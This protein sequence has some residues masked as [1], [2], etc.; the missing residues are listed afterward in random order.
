MTNSIYKSGLKRILSLVLAICMLFTAA[1]LSFATDGDD[2]FGTYGNTSVEPAEDLY[3]SIQKAY[4][5]DTAL[6]ILEGITYA[7]MTVGDA[8]EINAY[9]GTNCSWYDTD[10]W[11]FLSQTPAKAD[12]GNSAY[13]KFFGGSYGL[14]MW[15]KGT[16][17][18]IKVKANAG[19]YLPA[20][21]PYNIVGAGGLI[22]ASFYTYDAQSGSKGEL[23]AES[24]EIDTN[25]EYLTGEV[26]VPLSDTPLLLTEGEYVFRIEVTGTG[27]LPGARAWA[28]IN[29][30]A[31]NAVH[32]RPEIPKSIPVGESAEIPVYTA[33]HGVKLAS[34]S[35]EA[36]AADDTV[37]STATDTTTSTVT[38]QGLKAGTTTVTI[39][40]QGALN[41][42][43]TIPVTIYDPNTD[44]SK[45]FRYD[46]VKANTRAQSDVEVTWID[47]YNYAMPGTSEEY[48]TE[49][50][51]TDQYTLAPWKYFT[52][53]GSIEGLNQYRRYRNASYGIYMAGVVRTQYKILVPES[54]DYQINTYMAYY[55]GTSQALELSLAP[56]EADGTV[57][58]F[59]TLGSL[60][61]NTT[62]GTAFGKKATFDGTHQL[63][64]GEY[65]L[66]FNNKTKAIAY[67]ADA[68]ELESVKKAATL[69]VSAQETASVEKG[70][71]ASVP[72]TIT[73]SDS[74]AVDYTQATV[75]CTYGTADIVN[76]IVNKSADGITLQVEGLQAGSTTVTANV[77]ADGLTASASFTVTVTAPA[78][79]ED[80]GYYYDMFKVWDDAKTGTDESSHFYITTITY[81][82]TKQGG[83]SELNTS[84]YSDPWAYVSHNPTGAYNAANGLGGNRYIKFFAGQKTWGLAFANAGSASANNVKLS[85]KVEVD[86]DGLYQPFVKLCHGDACST[87]KATLETTDGTVLA[88]LN[89]YDSNG[90]ND[91]VKDV[92]IGD[93][94]ELKAGEYIF[95]LQATGT[96]KRAYLNGFGLKSAS[97]SEDPATLTVSAQD[98]ATVEA[99]SSVSVPL[100]ITRSDNQTVDYTQAEV[101]CEYGTAGVATV[102]PAKTAEGVTLQ[103]NGD[104]EGST[105]VTVN[106]AA[107][108]LT[109]SA[110][111]QVTVTPKGGAEAK[112]LYFN[113]YKIYTADARGNGSYID[114]IDYSK[115]TIGSG[116]SEINKYTQG[117][118]IKY[119]SDPWA[120]VSKHVAD[121]GYIQF[122]GFDYGLA[123]YKVGSK[124][125]VKVRVPADGVYQPMVDLTHLGGGCGNMQVTFSEYDS[126]SNAAGKTLAQSEVIN[127]GLTKQNGGVISPVGGQA[128]SLKAGEYAFTAELMAG[129]AALGIV[130]AFRLNVVRVRPEIPAPLKIGDTTTLSAFTGGSDVSV[131]SDKLE[132]TAS[133]DSIAGVTADATTG[134]LTLTAKAAGTVEVTV[135]AEGTV[136][137]SY[138]FPVTV[139]DPDAINTNT[140]RYDF[141]KANTYTN[142]NVDAQDV[143]LYNQTVSGV[144]D[145][146]NPAAADANVV[147]SPWKFY[148]WQGSLRDTTRA[149]YVSTEHGISMSSGGSGVVNFAYRIRVPMD[150]MYQMSQFAKVGAKETKGLTIKLSKLDANGVPQDISTL[151]TLNLGADEDQYGVENKLSG[152]VTLQAGEYL[153]IYSMGAGNTATVDSFNL[154]PVALD[155]DVT[156]PSAPVIID[157]TMNVP[158]DVTMLDGSPVD[159][160]NMSVQVS[161]SEDGIVEATPVIDTQEG[162][163]KIQVTGLSLGS[164]Q[165]TAKITVNGVSRVVNFLV[166]VDDGRAKDL[167]YDFQKG[168]TKL[169]STDYLQGITYNSTTAGAEGELNPGKYPTTPWAFHSWSLSAGGYFK[170]NYENTGIYMYR[171]GIAY[172]K[173]KV[174]ADGLYLP[175]ALIGCTTASGTPYGNVQ[176]FLMDYDAVTGKIGDELSK[177]EVIDYCSKTEAKMWIPMGNQP[178][179]L[180]AGEYIFGYEMSSSGSNYR[181]ALDAFRLNAIRLEPEAPRSI[182]VGE[183]V[184]I[185]AFRG[186]QLACDS[187][188]ASAAPS[189]IVDVSIDKQTGKLTLTGVAEGKTKLTVTAQGDYAGSYTIPV[190]VIDTENP[191]PDSVYYDF[192]KANT[193][194]DT[195]IRAL[196][197][198]SYNKT[199]GGA[200]DEINPSATND[201]DAQ[202]G[203][204]KYF[205]WYGDTTGDAFFGF[206]NASYGL[207]LNHR[208]TGMLRVVVPE[209]G[210]YQVAPVLSKL[211]NGGTVTI[212]I[213]PITG[214]GIPGKKTEFG[215]VVTKSDTVAH[216]VYTVLPGVLEI[217]AGEYILTVEMTDTAF[218]PKAIIDGILLKKLDV[219]TYVPGVAVARDGSKKQAVTATDSTG[220]AVDMT[221][222]VVTIRNSNDSIADVSSVIEDAKLYFQIDGKKNGS[223]TINF[224]FTLPDGRVGA[225]EFGIFVNPAGVVVADDLRYNFHKLD[226]WKETGNTDDKHK[227]VDIATVTSFAQTTAGDPQEIN[228]NSSELTDPWY[229]ESVAATQLRYA[230]SDYGLIFDYEPATAVFKIRVPADGLYQAVSENMQFTS[231]A[232]LKLYLAPDGAADPMADEYYLGSVDTYAQ[233]QDNA[234][235]NG[236]KIRNLTAGDYTLTYRM[237]GKNEA[238]RSAG[239][240]GIGAF[241]LNGMDSE[242]IVNATVDGPDMI[243]I[244]EIAEYTIN[245]QESDGLNGWTA[246][247]DIEVTQS[248]DGVLDTEVIYNSDK[249]A[250]KVKVTAVGN[251]NTIMSVKV[252]VNGVEKIISIPLTV[253]DPAA[254][255]DRDYKYTFI[256]SLPLSSKIAIVD[257]FSKTMAGSPDELRP[258]SGTDPWCF[259]FQQASDFYIPSDVYG[260]CLGIRPGAAAGIKIRLPVSGMFRPEMPYVAGNQCGEVRMYIAPADA[261][262]PMA[263]EYSVGKVDTYNENT[264]PL[265]NALF[266]SRWMDAGDYIVSWKL[267]GEDRSIEKKS[268]IWFGGVNL[269]A[270]NEFPEIDVTVGELAAVKLGNT[271]TTKIS[272]TVADGAPED[273]YGAEFRVESDVENAVTVEPKINDD[274]TADLAVTGL[275]VCKTDVDVILVLNGSDRARFTLPVEILAPGKLKT[276]QPK[277]TDNDEG[278]IVLRGTYENEKQ[279]TC[280]L[281][282]EE[283]VEISEFSA[284]LQGATYRYESENPSIA[285]VTE[286]GK[287]TPVSAGVTTVRATV[288]IAG[289]T[290]TGEMQ[291]TVSAGKTRS[292]YYTAEKVANARE[293][294]N[295]YDW[296]RSTKNAAASAG[297]KYVGMEDKLWSLV[298]TQ[299][300]PRSYYVGYR[301]DPEAGYCRYP[302][303]KVNIAAEYGSL[304]AWITDPLT[305]PWQVQCPKCRRKFPSNDFGSFYELGIDEHG[306]WSY[307]L[308]KQKNAELVAAGEDGYLVNKAY[309]EV[310]KQ[311]HVTGWGVDDGYGYDSGNMYSNGVKEV[312]T[313]ISFYNHWAI[314]HANG[315]LYTTVDALK[316]AYLYTG[317]AKYGRAGAILVDRIADVYPTLDTRPYRWQLTADASY[318]PKGKAVD[319]IWENQLARDY[320]KA[321]DAF[322]PMYD[323][324]TVIRFLSEKAEKYDLENP[325]TSANLIREN[326]ED[327]ILR[328]TFRAAQC[329]LLN[330]NFGMTQSAVAAAA[331]VLDTM[332]ETR[333]MLDWVFQDGET[334]VLDASSA[335]SQPDLITGGNVQRQIID[336]VDRD[337]VSDE[338]APNYANIW[339]GGLNTMM[340]VLEGYD[341]YPEMDMY[342]NPRVI[343]MLAGMHPLT[344]SRRSTVQIGDS[345]A[346]A[347]QDK[348]I[349]ASRALPAFKNT[350]IA[351]FGQILYF[352]NGNKSNGLHY[353]IFTKD[354][355]SLAKDVQKVIDA[356]GEYPFDDSKMLPG[357]GLAALRG[358]TQFKTQN[359]VVDSQRTFWMNFN[360]GAGHGHND[361]LN[362]GVEAYGLNIAPE[363]GYP[364]KVVG[365]VYPNWGKATVS[366]NTVVVNNTTQSRPSVTSNPLHFDDAGMVQVM[367]VDASERYG[368]TSNY[369]R[370]VVTVDA[371]D[372]ISYGVDFFRVTGGNDHTYSFHALTNLTPQ[373]GELDGTAI[374]MTPQKDANGNY[375]G[376]YAGANVP[377]EQA[378]VTSG[379]SYLKNV[380]RAAQPGNELYVDFKIQDF[381]KTI[382]TDYELYLRLT[383]LNDFD[384]SELAIAE[385]KPAEA[386]DNPEGLKFMLAKRTGANLDSLFTT[387][388]EPYNKERYVESMA[389]VPVTRADGSA[390]A[391]PAEVKAVKVTLTN[392]RSD[393][394]VYAA[395]KSI[396]YRVDDLF[397]FQGFVGVYSVKDGENVYAYL[398]DGTKLGDMRGET[399]YTGSVTGFTKE[400]SLENTITIAADQ[401]VDPAELEGKFI[402]ID[403]GASGNG[404][405]EI[406][407]A[408]SADGKNISLEIGDVTLIH[409][410]NTATAGEYTYYYNIAEGARFQIPRTALVD[411]RPVFE[412]VGNGRVFAENRYSVTVSAV[413]PID[414]ELSYEAVSLPRGA[415]FD[416]ATHTLTWTPDSSQIGVHHVAISAS[417]GALTATVHFEVQVAQ[418]GTGG[419][420]GGA[421]PNPEPDPEPNPDPDPTPNPDPDPDPTPGERFID[422][423]GYDWAKDAINELAEAGVIKGTSANT[424]SPGANITRADFAL[425]LTRAFKLTS[426]STENFADVAANKY[427]AAELAIAKANGIVNGIGNNKFKPEG[428][429]TRQDMMVMLERALKK[430]GYELGEAEGSELAAFSD[431]A[432]VADYAKEAAALLIGNGVVAGSNGRIN[433][434]GKATRAEVAVLL[435]RVLKLTPPTAAARRRCRR[436][437]GW[438]RYSNGRQAGGRRR[439]Y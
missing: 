241:R 81:D 98:S 106:V 141:T 256:K 237:E 366:H 262:D 333:E 425:L 11:E 45:T 363:L 87:V 324:A 391:N 168:F 2:G 56:V 422:L 382:S 204:W 3:Y 206:E 230:S 112:D 412:P 259:A 190:Q 284:Q 409:K 15:G 428:Q 25:T 405:Y 433:P 200:T 229:L 381:R 22:R 99:G 125:T 282:D 302:D 39:S 119:K 224:E 54:G 152:T 193:Y 105:T 222:A 417:D 296:A 236:L 227:G 254:A 30:F 185:Y 13:T 21:C 12:Q 298:T 340:E 344:M 51:S 133:D 343:K 147:L 270:L 219:N 278:I 371:D 384:L 18:E 102:T 266:R 368:T 318:A 304:Y 95:T 34:T 269:I 167:Y 196:E 215:S 389:Q 394:I 137:G 53:E 397:N 418:S 436:G 82:H 58:A 78:E 188:E 424:Y 244:G 327:G 392:G 369:R 172:F 46:F 317:E 255:A 110:T 415:S 52:W 117:G 403:G 86:K 365:D 121:G 180:K 135:T 77:T 393:Y 299:E 407:K 312:H 118:S 251:G 413:S 258:G 322:F 249:T 303:C 274:G 84:A 315:I 157:Q 10:P 218:I 347:S 202:T 176:T 88:L 181:G 367:D 385:G 427:Y 19:W 390:V 210:K 313:Y 166:T 28:A 402:Y 354:P 414:K 26:N 233:V 29:G 350:G 154:I 356:Y 6:G 20:V 310:D 158:I 228:P 430:L 173:I 395:D 49:R 348:M 283:G 326:C 332:P 201:Y 291:L 156:E 294:A 1:P 273:F 138:T 14:A 73:R 275:K 195:A 170:Y 212:G 131:A 214:D 41:G 128:L 92:D 438:S 383:M 62:E 164:V 292:S 63:E 372:E 316:N 257:S 290:V 264:Q 235:L 252:T 148:T 187:L 60:N 27:S 94:V 184:D 253:Y 136:S 76:A 44:S 179:E 378:N 342:N 361:G 377:F 207:A 221:G 61:L 321:Y 293:N 288:T 114:T 33:K 31:L 216:G 85:V 279:L 408:T 97:G 247:S 109:G 287:V 357:Y 323:D 96:K 17:L 132:A 260:A 64:A 149:Q 159:Y 423:G 286:D 334:F 189:G 37:L 250:N 48:H 139:Y 186:A 319:L 163:L 175:E 107:A 386:S 306:N 50:T 192:K 68:I 101:T 289:I 406:K 223:T 335:G 364:H 225:G 151:G 80:T 311:L 134:K 416:E 146:N 439:E 429:I 345:G 243:K 419:G 93:Q 83:A 240:A 400:L 421:T 108:G 267:V 280:V 36:T 43:Y 70:S 162:N 307:E 182:A 434:Q 329:G 38:V 127:T 404:A 374:E 376:S 398:N 145:E 183:S 308:A 295:A 355:E 42:T 208:V 4:T 129:S 220:A 197:Y 387:V 177:S 399:P 59:T 362:L 437:C 435:E 115:T 285:K 155:V 352:L 165:V 320:S 226:L 100:T 232:I 217:A 431:A 89:G 261:E 245:V 263:D 341:G 238:V 122:N 199:A 171:K 268:R 116:D 349:S 57:G 353:D 69:S 388:I 144:S 198:T 35:L 328:E 281:T 24:E 234:A 55:N 40:V 23:L 231:G 9:T 277:L 211:T 47:S 124:V 103:V 161:Y 331:V 174:P 351:E 66:R 265:T 426:D 123:L 140:F 194:T 8:G 120:F 410:V 379:Y 104:A 401:S 380:D 130:D 160:Q 272:A 325:K 314:W 191:H 239:R 153:L 91:E 346:V 209:S 67:V 373:V 242:T 358:G 111:F 7:N 297:N 142:Y 300:L 205:S 301:N 246:A 420:G 396:E 169:S 411:N 336:K 72:L 339:I 213:A 65:V 360:R 375:V 150:G 79:P 74:Q 370:T 178:V 203:A 16:A 309:P 276:V 143:R 126:S 5:G 330:G 248:A 337:G 305:M 338:I 359:G 113:M 271:V 432:Q 90:S 75:E 32:V 71:S